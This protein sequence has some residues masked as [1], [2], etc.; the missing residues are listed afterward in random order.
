MSK[1][2]FSIIMALLCTIAGKDPSN[3][4]Q[5]GLLCVGILHAGLAIVY[6]IKEL[7]G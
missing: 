3:I 7:R 5:M 4:F 1:Y 2:Q 6:G